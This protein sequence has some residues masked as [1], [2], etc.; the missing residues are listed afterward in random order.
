MS[1]ASYIP[2]SMK[3]LIVF[4]HPEPNS[5]NGAM[6]RTAE[7]TLRAPEFELRVSNLHAM[8]FNPVPGRHDFTSRAVDEVFSYQSEQMHAHERG[9]FADDVRLEQEKLLWADLLILQFPLWWFGMPA[10]LKG[11]VDRVLAYGFAYGGGRWYDSGV[12]RDKRGML[13]LTTGGPA[14][15]YA[16]DGLQ[17]SIETILFPIHHGV[18]QFV[19]LQVLP[20]FVAYSAESASEEGRERVLAAYAKRLRSARTDPTF[21]EVRLSDYDDDLRKRRDR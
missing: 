20:P 12:L 14:S 9:T 21:P 8:E 6:L 2:M 7:D 17:G 16:E 5:F 3:V 15:A 10:I 13:A 1:G 4:A 19:G 11:W 18:L